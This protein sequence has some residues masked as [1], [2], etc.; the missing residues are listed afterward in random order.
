MALTNKQRVFVEEYLRTWNATEAALRAGYSEKTARAIGAE[1]LTKPD[2]SEEI[3]ARLAEIHM[4]TDEALALLADHARGDIGE[5]M[6]VSRAGFNLELLDENGN[7]KN[8]RV[9]KKIKQKTTTFIAKKE[10]DEDR[11]V[12]EIEIELYDAQAAIDKVLRVAGKYKDTAGIN[13]EGMVK[14]V[15]EYANSNPYPTEAA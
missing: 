2:I 12:H 9:I 1:N 8:T 5:F 4:T 10:S 15:V 3:Q 11:E 6:D 7:R 13:L 14:I